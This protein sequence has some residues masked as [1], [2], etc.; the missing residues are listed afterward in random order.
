MKWWKPIGRW[1]TGN[2]VSDAIG[3]Q[4]VYEVEKGRVLFVKLVCISGRREDTATNYLNVDLYVKDYATG[5]IT[6]RIGRIYSDPGY[7]PDHAYSCHN[8]ET[9]VTYPEKIVMNVSAGN[10]LSAQICGLE[11]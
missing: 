10:K 8:V 6:K 5:T 7:G 4:P 3:E 2:N 9:V 1:V 11:V